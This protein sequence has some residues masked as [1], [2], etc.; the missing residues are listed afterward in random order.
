[1]G[2]RSWIIRCETHLDLVDLIE[3]IMWNEDNWHTY[4]G[5]ITWKGNRCIL[6]A[7]DGSVNIDRYLCAR[8]HYF[9][10][11]LD[12]VPNNHGK[13]IGAN[14]MDSDNANEIYGKLTIEVL[15]FVV[16]YRPGGLR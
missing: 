6:L 2:L 1:M 13:I 15:R 11:L 3:S 7:S 16:G 9:I 12:N 14:Y 5:F 4:A 10:K 8:K